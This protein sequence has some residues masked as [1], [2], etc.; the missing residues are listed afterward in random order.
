MMSLFIVIIARCLLVLLFLPFSALDKLLNF[1]QAVAQASQA[2]APLWLAKLLIGVGCLVE[3]AMSI[4]IL[5][6]IADRF[7]A[8][9]LGSYCIVT[10]ILWKPFWRA[11]DFRLRGPSLGRDVFWDFLKNCAL[12]GGL[13]LL[14]FGTNVSGVQRFLD[15]PLSS[16]Y[17]YATFHHEQTRP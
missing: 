16:S 2:V 7:A 6:G 11:A 10:A 4:A 5:A 8:F 14:A 15:H 13:F 12:A 9:I 1:K 3:V 17:P